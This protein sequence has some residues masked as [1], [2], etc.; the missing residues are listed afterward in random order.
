MIKSPPEKTQRLMA[1]LAYDD[2]PAAIEFLCRAFGFEETAGLRRAVKSSTQRSR[3]RVKGFSELHL[4]PK[5]ARVPDN[6]AVFRFNSFAMSMTSTATTQQP[7]PKGRRFSVLLRTSSG[8]IAPMRLWTARATAGLFVR[9]SR[10][11][12]SL[13]RSLSKPIMVIRA[14]QPTPP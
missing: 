2:A 14:D 10:M 1:R 6:R 5:L 12:R 3:C 13:T 7:G 9:S 11:C 8:A 4:H